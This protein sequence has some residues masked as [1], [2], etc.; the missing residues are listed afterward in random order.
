V[1]LVVGGLLFGLGRKIIHVKRLWQ[2]HGRI[3]VQSLDVQNV[4]RGRACR[5]M[6]SWRVDTR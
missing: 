3:D 5:R 2:A 6:G 4:A 1:L